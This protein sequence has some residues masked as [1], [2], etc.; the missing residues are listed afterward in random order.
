[1]NNAA[2]FQFG[3]AK[4]PGEGKHPVAQYETDA[5]AMRK[6]TERLRALRLARDAELAAANPAPATKK[7]RKVKP[8]K[9]RPATLS[10][11]WKNQKEDGRAG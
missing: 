2:E 1:M 9:D 6:K 5:A 7:V 4:Q 3:K 8:V 11:W 10:E